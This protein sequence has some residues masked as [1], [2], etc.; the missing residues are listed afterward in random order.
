[1]LFILMLYAVKYFDISNLPLN[2]IYFPNSKISYANSSILLNHYPS[3]HGE[4]FALGKLIVVI[5]TYE[6]T[7]KIYDI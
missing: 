6:K 7:K 1:M 5:Y 3:V 4:F 2:A